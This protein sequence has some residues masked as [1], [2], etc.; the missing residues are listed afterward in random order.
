M[1]D[2]EN[3]NILEEGVGVWNRW[4]EENPDVRPSLRG[5]DLYQAD[6][7]EANLRGADLRRA[8]L[9]KAILVK[10]ILV[11]AILLQ[12]DLSGADLSGANL[13][14]A[15]LSRAIL[16]GADFRDAVLSGADLSGVKVGYTVFADLNL[17]AVKGLDAVD[18]IGPSSISIDVIYRSRGKIPG[19]FL[20][21]AG[22]PDAFIASLADQPIRYYFCFISYSSKDEAFAQ[23][24]HADLQQ[25]GVRCWLAP[26]DIAGGKKIYDQGIRLH[27]KLLLVLSEN[28]IY[29]EWMITEIRRA[30]QA[31]IRDGRRK[32]FP[33]RLV[34]R[35]TLKDWECFDADASRDLAVEVR[36][37]FI[38]DFSDWKDHDSYQRAFDSL[39]RDLIAEEG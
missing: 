38:S 16:S 26:E 15:I 36:E 2:E 17:G 8:I 7:R 11:K 21:G 30:R 22:V 39:L 10:A 28:S 34:D 5:A 32:L 6:L 37:H 35:E 31:E 3:L 4:R 23:H 14:G 27:D 24:L 12:A 18:H 29:S 1:A 33:I 13:S 25:K 20:R 9:R 19:A